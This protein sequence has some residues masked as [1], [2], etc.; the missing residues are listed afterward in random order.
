MENKKEIERCENNDTLPIIKLHIHTHTHTHTHA[1]ART[2]THTAKKLR[3]YD[4]SEYN[5]KIILKII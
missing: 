1:R 2:H 3:I 4:G 5:N